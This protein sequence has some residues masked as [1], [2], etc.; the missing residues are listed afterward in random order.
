[1]GIWGDHQQ[2]HKAPHNV[3]PAGEDDAWAVSV[4]AWLYRR[5]LLAYPAPF[6][7]AFAIEL[8]QIFRV[9]C[10]EALRAGGGGALARLWL[11]TLA[12]LV[13]SAL[14]ERLTG[15]YI[16]ASTRISRFGGLVGLAGGA[17][18]L[19]MLVI[20]VA[21]T[22]F[23]AFA[24]VTPTPNATVLATFVPLYGAW[25][26]F[27]VG[28]AGLTSRLASVSGSFWLRWGAIVA[29]GIACVGAIML[30]AGNLET[31]YVWMLN[32]QSSVHQVS[33]NGADAAFSYAFYAAAF[34]GYLVLGVGLALLGIV[35]ARTR[36]LGRWSILPS[37]MGGVAAI[38]YFFTDMGA[39]SLLRN[40]N[41]GTVVMA[42]A[43]L[44]FML[45]WGVC[46]LVIGVT[47]LRANHQSAP[48]PSGR[49]VS[50]HEQ[51]ATGISG[52]VS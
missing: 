24:Q 9:C 20:G 46:W 25:L 17:L 7:R 35:A 47:L 16:M 30:L 31:S 52:A 37:L 10:R 39:P 51:A 8:A 48:Q 15:G 38:M 18:W 45:F 1:M 3:Q 32:S 21:L 34:V 14:A 33:N 6:R 19:A 5:C 50:A 22:V 36:A 49:S 2:L 23:F 12:D 29:G 26:L 43:M 42:I 27:L 41:P 28:L 11:F 44:A 4:S 13:F 40:T